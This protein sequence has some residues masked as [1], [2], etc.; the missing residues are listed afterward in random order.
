M[1]HYSACRPSFHARVR[2]CSSLLPPPM[3]Q[4]PHAKPLKP[5]PLIKWQLFTREKGIN[6]KQQG[7]KVWDDER[8]A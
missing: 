8:Q 3:T 1:G 5:K 7:K 2:S 6:P 4:L